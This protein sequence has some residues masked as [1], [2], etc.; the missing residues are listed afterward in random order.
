M[1]GYKTYIYNFN[2]SEIYYFIGYITYLVHNIKNNLL[3]LIFCYKSLTYKQ[4]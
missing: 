3:E 2:V 4:K 1:F